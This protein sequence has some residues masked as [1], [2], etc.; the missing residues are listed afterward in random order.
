[1]ESIALAQA[2]KLRVEVEPYE[3]ADGREALDRLDRGL[4]RGRAVLVP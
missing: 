1:M 3:L 4:V 2:G